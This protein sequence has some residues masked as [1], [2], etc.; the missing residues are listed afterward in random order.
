MMRLALWIGAI[1]LFGAVLNA[2][3]I[4]T[5]APSTVT[6][7]FS[8]ILTVIFA[9]Y[10]YSPAGVL[11]AFLLGIMVDFASAQFVGPN[12]AGC[13][14]A[15]CAV[16]LIANRMYAEKWLALMIIT[17]A[18]SIVKSLTY[19]G[20]VSL[21][22][23]TQIG[24]SIRN[25]VLGEAFVTAIFA[26]IIIGLVRKRALRSVAFGGKPVQNNR[27]TSS[28]RTKQWS[29]KASLRGIS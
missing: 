16:G 8:L 3:L 23:P 10:F 20:F 13:V 1:S 4:R 11:V 12:A 2:A 18:C 21:Y 14:M 24:E 28:T 22:F 25:T 6:P 26:P 15:F 9:L 7:D 27:S 19:V 29:A 5:I 17:F